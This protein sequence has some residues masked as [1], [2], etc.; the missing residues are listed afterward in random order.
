MVDVKAF[1]KY[2]PHLLKRHLEKKDLGDWVLAEVGRFEK[3]SLSLYH[4]LFLLTQ[5][6]HSALVR[7]VWQMPPLH[8][9]LEGIMTKS[10]QM[11]MGSGPNLKRGN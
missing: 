1:R 7:S 4:C 2:A 3:K 6:T 11:Q 8:V 9:P 5:P 10:H